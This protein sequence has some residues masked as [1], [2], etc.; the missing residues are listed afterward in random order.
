[1]PI[2]ALETQAYQPAAAVWPPQKV[3]DEPPPTPARS[4]PALIE[5]Q[6]QAVA[7]R[8]EE[9]ERV[10]RLTA[11]SL[12]RLLG[13]AGESLVESRWLRPFADSLQRL[14]R[15]QAELAQRLDR[16]RQC[17][18]DEDLSERP[19]AQVHGWPRPVRDSQQVLTE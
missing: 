14:K 4:R 10:V 18:E 19:A 9:P 7:L 5:A 2:I 12:N 8:K 15:Q 3:T 17:L 11:D 13:L 1:A 6:S 16:L